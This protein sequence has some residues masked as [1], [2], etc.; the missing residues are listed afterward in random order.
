MSYD[1]GDEMWMCTKCAL[2]QQICYYD[3][4][5]VTQGSMDKLL[6]KIE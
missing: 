5:V 4:D 6:Q 3:K 2:R 1:C